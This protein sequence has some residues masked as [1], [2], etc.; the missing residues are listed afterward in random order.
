MREKTLYADTSF[1]IDLFN[2][3]KEAVHIL[4]EA[5]SIVTGSVCVYELS[6]IAE[7]DRSKLKGNTILDLGKGDVRQA[8]G[9]YRDLSE[10]GEKIGEVDYLIAGQ[11]SNRD[12]VLVTRDR[13]FRKLDLQTR[14]YSV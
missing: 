14:Q 1:L 7:F 10:R 12:L 5:E 4:D 9:F 11:V 8:A 2:G 6:K 13:D 3:R